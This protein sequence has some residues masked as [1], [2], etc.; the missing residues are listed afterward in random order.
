MRCTTGR[1]RNSVLRH[2]RLARHTAYRGSHAGVCCVT[3]WDHSRRRLACSSATR[4]I[5]S[6]D[7]SGRFMH[8][9]TCMLPSVVSLGPGHKAN[10]NI[11][12]KSKCH[13]SIQR[14]KNVCY[15]DSTLQ[16]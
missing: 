2:E 13:P 9:S 3:S 12:N 11:W 8:G 1:E 16:T 4:C 15:L 7:W 14:I 5:V 6:H 10:F